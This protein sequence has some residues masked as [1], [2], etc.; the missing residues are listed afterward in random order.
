MTDGAGIMNRTAKAP[1]R[2][3]VAKWLLEAYST[4]PE[5]IGRNEWKKQGYKWV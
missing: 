2:K 3:Q 4:M 5:E 1:R